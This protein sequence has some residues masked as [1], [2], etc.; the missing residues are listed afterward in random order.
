MKYKIHTPA[1]ASN[2]FS[3]EYRRR[4]T[5]LPFGGKMI[6]ARLVT[7]I[8]LTSALHYGNERLPAWILD[9]TETDGLSHEDQDHF[10][11]FRE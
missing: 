3:A 9:G 5:D 4:D 11:T 6:T 1:H 10:Q 8:L 2:G 7:E